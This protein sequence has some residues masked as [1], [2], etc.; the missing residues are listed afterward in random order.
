[1]KP[2]LSIFLLLVISGIFTS[3]KLKPGNEYIANDTISMKLND[4]APVDLTTDIS[5][6]T[7]KEKQLIAI[8]IE[9]ADIMDEIFWIQAY[10]DKDTLLEKLSS[11]EEVQL[12]NIHYGPWDRMSGNDPFF[13]GTGPKPPG[14]NFYP[15]DMTIEEFEKL[16]DTRKTSLYTLIRRNEQGQLTVIPYHQAFREKVQKASTLLTRAASYAEDPGLKRYLKLRAKG[17]LNDDYRA[18]DLAWMEMKTNTI[19]FVVGPVETYE[20]QLFGY[21]ASH[22]AYLLVKD[23]VWSRR[24][25]HYLALLPALQQSLPVDNHYKSALPE[26]GSDLGAYD[27]I[28]YAGECKAGSKTIAINLPNDKYVQQVKGSRRVQLKN[29]MKAKF[30]KIMVPIAKEVLAAEHLPNVTFDAFFANTMFHEIAHGL[31]PAK[32]ISK[33]GSIREA[34]MEYHTTIEESKADVVGIY[35]ID[36]LRSMGEIELNTKD[37]YTTFMAGIFRSIRFG[38]SNAHGKANLIRYNY[39]MEA[40]AISRDSLGFYHIDY[41]KTKE[42]VHSLSALLLKLQGDG[43]YQLAAGLLKKYGTI[44]PLLKADL[45][46][47]TRKDIPVDICFEQGPGVLGL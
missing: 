27:V 16:E 29:A 45:D 31:G 36:Q 24:L 19:D 47:I 22:E 26:K 23:T 46:R 15:A 42:A 44:G 7:V 6:L 3:C 2:L 12:V 40:G 35:L 18:S 11:D 20:D 38:A 4:F 32:T 25:N 43:N 9:V 39:F 41:Q 17:F 28:Y 5:K 21:K 13:K 37:S 10:G 34:L 8:L 33:N 1:M 14:A 30:D